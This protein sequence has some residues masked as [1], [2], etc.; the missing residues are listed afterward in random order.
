MDVYVRLP[1]IL[2]QEFLVLWRQVES[3]APTFSHDAQ[4]LI[5]KVGDTI[6]KFKTQVRSSECENTG[7]LKQP[8]NVVLDFSPQY[9]F[10]WGP[11]KLDTPVIYPQLKSPTN[12]SFQI[13]Q[14]LTSHPAHQ[15]ILINA[16][17]RLY[18]LMLVHTD[19]ITD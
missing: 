7:A 17:S 11:L 2:F 18:R 19:Q 10:N 16:V 8:L 9:L 13:L 15:V 4:D 1:K 14:L 5:G 6:G 12:S 3:I